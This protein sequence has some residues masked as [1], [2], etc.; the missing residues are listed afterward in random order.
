MDNKLVNDI[1]LLVNNYMNEQAK[2]FEIMKETH[3]YLLKIPFVKNL[4][5][6][7]EKLK[8]TIKGF[9]N[10][11]SLEIVD[12]KDKNNVVLNDTI[13]KEVDEEEEVEVVE[14]EEEEVEVEEEEEEEEEVEV[15]EVEEEEE[16]EEVE[17]VEVEE[18]EEDEEEEVEVEEEEEEEEEVE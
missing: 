13:E 12:K 7:N 15:V 18:E 1:S 17:V 16:E 8:N 6:E 11:I 3:E 9:K 4:I 14:D 2:Q 10:N 5:L